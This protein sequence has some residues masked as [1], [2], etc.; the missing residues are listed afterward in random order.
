MTFDFTLLHTD[1]DSHARSGR[2]VTPHGEIATPAFAPVGTQATV[3]ALR[4]SD[5]HE[6]G[7]TLVL[8]NTYHL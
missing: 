8:G 3:K 6:L 7:A 2:I 4:P 1:S 5:L